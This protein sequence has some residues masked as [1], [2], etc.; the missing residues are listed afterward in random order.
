MKPKR[1]FVH[2]ALHVALTH[3]TVGKDN[4]GTKQWNEAVAH[5]IALHV[6]HCTIARPMGLRPMTS[7]LCIPPAIPIRTS[8]NNNSDLNVESIKTGY[9]Y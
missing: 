7:Q 6:A 1:K 4:S 3:G 8:I 9:R 2:I 5:C